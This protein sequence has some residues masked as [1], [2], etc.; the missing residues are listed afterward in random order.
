MAKVGRPRLFP[1]R[2]TIAERVRRSRQLHGNKPNTK[3]VWLSGRLW[4]VYALL[5]PRIGDRPFYI[6]CTSSLV[7]RYYA[8]TVY[9]RDSRAWKRCQTI[10]RGGLFVGL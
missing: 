1:R 9:D 6:G 4:H 2:L 8:H 10:I 5:D 7:R 3:A